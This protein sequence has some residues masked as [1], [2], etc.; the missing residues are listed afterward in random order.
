VKPASFTPAYVAFYPALA[1][2]AR[3]HGYA[4]AVHGSV[5]RDM[6]LLA[7]PWTDKAASAETLMRTIAEYATSVLSAMFSSATTVVGPEAKPHGRTAWSIII[8][9]G[10]VIDLSVM[11]H[12]LSDGDRDSARVYAHN[13]PMLADEIDCQ[14]ANTRCDRCGVMDP[15]T[16]VVECPRSDRGECD[17]DKAEELRDA[18][19]LLA[20]LASAPGATGGES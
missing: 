18:A 13:L 20:K 9:N 5:A 19:K 2:I 4:L 3:K 10:S 7:A 14:D 1:E 8:G 15:T 6:D 12:G 11:P 16:G 17:N